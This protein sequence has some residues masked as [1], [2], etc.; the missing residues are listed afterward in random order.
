LVCLLA[1]LFPY[2]YTILFWQFYS[3][4]FSVHVQTIVIY[5]ALLSLLWCVTCIMGEFSFHSTVCT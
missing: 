1:L 4:P 5:A 3:R 2:S